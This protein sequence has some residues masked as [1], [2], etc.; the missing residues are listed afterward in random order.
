MARTKSA[1]DASATVAGRGDLPSADAIAAL[2]SWAEGLAAREALH[3][4]LKNTKAGGQSSRALLSATR[5][6]LVQASVRRRRPD[7]QAVFEATARGSF[8]K[9]GLALNLTEAVDELAA[10]AVAI[11]RLMDEVS[12][13]FDAR[14]VSA[15]AAQKIRTLADLTVR[16]PR[17]KMWWVG[18]EGLGARG[19]AKIS[20][21]F[22]ANPELTAHARSL[23]GPVLRGDVQPW[24]LLRIPSQLDGSAGHFRAPV[25]TCALNAR[26]DYEAVS[27]WL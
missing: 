6:Q 13:W 8:A 11:P 5:N 27:A 25:H 21:L 2:R 23:V 17:R 18:I 15:L 12:L 10:T 26:N 1:E 24:E 9:T 7:L 14:A 4:Y 20:G 16:I 22:A 19:A 3:R